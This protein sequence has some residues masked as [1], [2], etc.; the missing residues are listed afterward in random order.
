MLEKSLSN[1]YSTLKL[2][3]NTICYAVELSIFRISLSEIPGNLKIFN[4]E[5][6]KM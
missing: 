4:T 6:P 5:R 1:V 2:H 3:C